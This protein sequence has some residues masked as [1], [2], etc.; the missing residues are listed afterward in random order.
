[1]RLEDGVKVYVKQYLE[2]RNIDISEDEIDAI[3][4]QILD[5]VAD[6]IDQELDQLL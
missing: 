5:T 4:I 1:M 3:T 6:T 2:E